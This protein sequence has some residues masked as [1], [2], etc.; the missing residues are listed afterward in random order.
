MAMDKKLISAFVLLSLFLNLIVTGYAQ[1]LSGHNYLVGDANA[2]GEAHGDEKPPLN[3]DWIGGGILLGSLFGVFLGI[4]GA[5]LGA[6]IAGDPEPVANPRGF[7]MVNMH[8]IELIIIG[9]AIGYILGSATGVYVAGTRG[10]VT[11]SF[12]SAFLGSM[13]GCCIP[14]PLGSPIGAAIVFNKTRRYKSSSE[15]GT[16]LINFRNGQMS[17]AV[18]KVYSRPESFGSGNLS[19]R[20]DLL[21]V[22]F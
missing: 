7:P 22:R 10:D 2:E 1:Q 20:V 5:G 6:T 4:A 3:N 12:R 19:Q 21:R 15:P 11:G 13:A 17:L 16:A 9:S 18:P 14:L 8:G